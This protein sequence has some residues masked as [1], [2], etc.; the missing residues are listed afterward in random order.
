MDEPHSGNGRKW[1]MKIFQLGQHVKFHGFRMHSEAVVE[2]VNEVTYSWRTNFLHPSISS[3][4]KLQ[5][6]KF[7][8]SYVKLNQGF[9]CW[10]ADKLVQRSQFVVSKECS[11]NFCL[12]CIHCFYLWVLLVQNPMK[13]DLIAQLIDLID[14]KFRMKW[15][16]IQI[17]HFTF[18]HSYGID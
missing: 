12:H 13:E 6:C 7:G 10:P 5:I 18:M 8:W 9:V 17:R 2:L 1:T 16:P 11:V 15:S 3:F 4:L 14:W